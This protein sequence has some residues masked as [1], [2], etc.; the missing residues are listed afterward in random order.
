[1]ANAL[2]AGSC[3]KFTIANK[4]MKHEECERGCV[5]K[6]ILQ[7]CIRHASHMIIM[8]GKSVVVIKM[9]Q[10]DWR[11]A[12][13]TTHRGSTYK[14]VISLIHTRAREHACTLST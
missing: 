13:Y 9:M 3:F 10:P 12:N 6:R 11:L 14:R 7:E 2:Y 8:S 1:M 5:Y 4:P